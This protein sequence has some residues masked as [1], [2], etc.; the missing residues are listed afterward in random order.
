MNSNNKKCMTKI[1]I[2]LEIK[3][4]ATAQTAE[5]CRYLKEIRI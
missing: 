1:S 5:L 2:Y 4:E 3:K